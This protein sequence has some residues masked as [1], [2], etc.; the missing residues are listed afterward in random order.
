MYNDMG[1]A[2]SLAN[3]VASIVVQHPGTYSLTSE[4]V[5]FL[6]S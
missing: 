2:I 5:S 4:D 1:S 6:L 3:E